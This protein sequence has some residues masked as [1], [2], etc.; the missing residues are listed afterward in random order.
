MKISNPVLL[1]LYLPKE[2]KEA[3]VKLCFQSDTTMS[4]EVRRFVREFIANP[5]TVDRL[6]YLPKD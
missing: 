2:E 5:P 4:R 3:F 6:Y 1:Q